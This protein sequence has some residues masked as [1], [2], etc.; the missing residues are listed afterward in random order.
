MQNPL[1]GYSAT[2]F[3]KGKSANM[4]AVI[5]GDRFPFTRSWS[6]PP[7]AAE[8]SQASGS[9]V[10]RAE[11][12]VHDGKYQEA[13]DLL[14]PVQTS[15]SG[16]SMFNYLLGRAALG[17][18]QEDDAMKFFERSIE[19]RPG[20]VAPHLG[21]GRAYF[22]LGDY[23][24]A[25]IEFETVLRFDNLPP[26]LL[27]QIEIYD[28]AA[29]QYLDKDRGLIGFAFVQAGVGHYWEHNTA[30]PG[31]SAEDNDLRKEPFYEGRAGIGLDQALSETY[32]LDGNLDYRFRTFDNPAIRNDSDWRWVGE[33]SRTLGESNL[34]L[35]VRGRV[36]N[37]G[38]GYR[39]DYGVFGSWRYRLNPTN[40]LSIELEV[41]RRSYP[42]GPERDLSR[43][44]SEAWLRWTHT[45]SNRSDFSISANGAG[46][47]QA[48][49]PDG[50]RSVSGLA[51]TFNIVLAS[52][53]DVFMSGLWQHHN[54][55]E[56]REHFN[57]VLDTVGEFSRTDNEYELGGGVVWDLKRGWSLRP[58]FLYTREVSNVPIN[59]YH[60]T[61]LRINVRK[62]FY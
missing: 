11:Q 20:W 52:R 7:V 24:Q 12:L 23:S 46:Q 5:K 13:Y 8:Q 6:M 38:N 62:N 33:V 49:I 28:K 4:V 32:L 18:G 59:D 39:N 50:N 19:L 53:L 31:A 14:T 17:I 2:L 55:N 35:G 36:S 25:K 22:A 48:N 37:R 16:D 21:L 29:K 45:L 40:Q 41:R 3:Q 10:A 57:P 27:T 56:N 58:E 43:N 60:S 61:E 42:S 51:G 47:W 9:D 26:E 1:E 30:L 54:F 15:L 34:A 44:I